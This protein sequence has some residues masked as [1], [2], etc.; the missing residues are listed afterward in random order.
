METVYCNSGILNI[1][2]GAEGNHKVGR[3]LLGHDK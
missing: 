2:E 3:A 1:N